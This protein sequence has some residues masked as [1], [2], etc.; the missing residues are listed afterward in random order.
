MT[1]EISAQG[2]DWILPD[3]VFDGQRLCFDTAVLMRDG[4]AVDMRKG[5]VARPV[6]GI[7]TPGFFDIQV[8]GG[9]GVL[10]NT[11]PDYAGAA[12]IAQAHARFGT[13]GIL[14]TLI[15]DAP[16]ALQSA[17]NDILANGLPEGVLGIH[18]EGPHISIER[19]GT[20]N[21]DLIRPLD[22]PTLDIVTSLRQQNV[23]VLIT[24]A[25]EA[26]T[27]E[28]VRQ[29]IDRGAVVSLGHSNCTAA[30][31]NAY[32]D[33]GASLVTHLFNG[34]S[35]MTSREPGLVGAAI[36][37]DVCASIICDGIHV[38]PD[39]IDLA[40]RARRSADRMILIS[41]AMPTVGGDPEFDL[42]GKT[43]RLNGNTL[44]N[45]SGNLA[46]AHVTMAEAVS[47][48]VE[49]V[50]IDTETALRAAI[51]NPAELM[52]VAER[53]DLMKGATPFLWSSQKGGP[54]A[55]TSLPAS[56]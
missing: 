39:M 29:L 32:F 27:Q 12:A 21:P 53:F 44:L 24:I 41:D 9:G 28:Q 22:A 54:Q 42:Y 52:G 25:P 51:T 15:T 8:N 48:C 6:G 3:A 26:A 11:Q 49:T 16:G 47:Y 40:F 1:A 2:E 38:A 4:Q 45:S 14:T 5:A 36:N 13:T 56:A 50:G 7:L 10:Y 55:D 19:K 23:P 34:M 35:Q 17:A 43:I 31:A 46:G 30:T 37:S 33:A 18:I 20:H